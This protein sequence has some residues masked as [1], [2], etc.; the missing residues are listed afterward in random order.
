MDGTL[1]NEHSLITLM[2]SLKEKFP[3]SYNDFIENKNNDLKIL[4][5][6]T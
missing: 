5:E 2:Y 6:E 3:E 4:I 1:I